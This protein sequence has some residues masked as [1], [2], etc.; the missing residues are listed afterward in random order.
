MSSKPDIK[1][2]IFDSEG[3][4]KRPEPQR[5]TSDVRPAPAPRQP[6]RELYRSESFQAA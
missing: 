2:R 3:L 6:K 5:N 4:S 1:A